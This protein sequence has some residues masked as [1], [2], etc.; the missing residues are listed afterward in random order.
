MNDRTENDKT[1]RVVWITGASSGIGAALAHEFSARNDLLVLSA[2]RVDRLEALAAEL[3]GDVFVLPLD[4]TDFESHAVAVKTVLDRFGRIDIL[5]HNAG[6]SQR[7]LVV[8]TELSVVR[9]LVDV[10]LIGSISLT[11]AA[12]PTMIEAGGG[13]FVVVSSLV[14][15][16]GTPKRSAYSAAKHGLHGYFESL[17][18][19]LYGRG[20]RVTMVCPGFV[21]TEITYHALTGDGS[22]QGTLDRA[23]AEGMKPEECARRVVKAIDAGRAQVL[24]GGREVAM[25]WIARLAPWLYRRLIRRVAVT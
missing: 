7:S 17:R 13:R 6:I 1:P 18:A 8:D 12:L 10:D 3:D 9:R 16:F 21:R 11:Q 20:I 24:I 14:G 4:L 19:E 23:Q 22:E 2:R 15:L 25:A 5:V